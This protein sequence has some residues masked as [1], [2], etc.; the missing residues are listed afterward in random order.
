MPTD[1]KAYKPE[2]FDTWFDEGDDD[3]YDG[4]SVITDVLLV[5]GKNR[6]QTLGP[7]FT[8]QAKSLGYDDDPAVQ[9]A[10]KRVDIKYLRC[11][12]IASFYLVDRG[13]RHRLPV[14]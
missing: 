6:L 10:Y 8:V 5:P 12:L 13:P 7:N 3:E 14:D 9:R 4:Y 1:V 2:V 11:G